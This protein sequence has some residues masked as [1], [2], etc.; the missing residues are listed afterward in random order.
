MLLR[1]VLG[2]FVK[3]ERSLQEEIIQRGPDDLRKLI[4]ELNVL[5]RH[6]T[7]YP[8]GHP[9][10]ERTL[11]R[12]HA[13]LSALLFGSVSLVIGVT[14][15]ALIVGEE[16]IEAKDP[17]VLDFASSLFSLGIVTLTFTSGVTPEEL[18]RFNECLMAQE[19]A[20]AQDGVLRMLDDARLEHIRV[21]T[22]DYGAFSVR[23]GTDGETET[24]TGNL[25]E[26]FVRGVLAGT[27]FGPAINAADA[28]TISDATPELL[29]EMLQDEIAHK[30]GDT[31]PAILGLLAQFLRQVDQDTMTQDPRE[32]AKFIRFLHSLNPD[33]RDYFLQTCFAALSERPA[34]AEKLLDGF[35]EEMIVEALSK[36]LKKDNYAPPP[37]LIILQRLA[38][39]RNI[40]LPDISA[41]DLPAEAADAVADSLQRK[42]R[43]IFQEEDLEKLVP[44]KDYQALHSLLDS[45]TLS[46]QEE[47]EIVELKKTF[48]DRWVEIKISHI[49]LEL[50]DISAGDPQHVNM[51]SRNLVDLCGYFVRTGEFDI[52]TGIFDRM[53]KLEH[54]DDYGRTMQNAFAQPDFIDEVLQSSMI[55]GKQ[56]FEDIAVLV[57]HIGLPFVDPMLDRLAEE[58]S[59]SLRRFYIDR[60]IE[61]GPPAIDLI[62]ARL[63]D[64][65]W[66]F[67]RNLAL[68][69]SSIGSRAVIPLLGRLQRHEHPKVRQEVLK[70]L[71]DLKDAGGLQMLADDLSSRDRDVRMAAILLATQHGSPEIVRKLQSIID[72]EGFSE[73]EVQRKVAAIQALSV[74][75]DVSCLPVFE[76]ILRR[77]HFFRR[78]ALQQVKEEIVS[79]LGSFSSPNALE[80]LR[81]VRKFGSKQLADKAEEVERQMRELRYEP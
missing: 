42:L 27:L 2:R 73:D 50:L 11:T 72:T 40:T 15:N 36:G 76:K 14:K 34:I 29:A 66:Y 24:E 10:V 38:K 20:D 58:E 18:Q 59:L 41:G 26:R 37:I 49:I 56:K 64:G 75:N 44:E 80:L 17:A 7:A 3:Q 61:C 81:L 74:I 4:Y 16:K 43:V 69:L 1:A 21:Q 12:A 46:P 47:Q 71:L 67:V 13:T 19:Q 77:K 6:I 63:K 51:L 5:R 25:W 35:S 79:A 39:S 32:L 78:A 52:L 30:R 31:V 70:A 28:G 62:G 45:D 57:R 55:W 53:Q 48:E 23:Y 33:M 8:H 22:I 65:R 60:I 68:I 9:M 54:A